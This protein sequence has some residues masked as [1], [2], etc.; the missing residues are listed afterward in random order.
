MVDLG[1]PAG[2]PPSAKSPFLILVDSC[3]QANPRAKR[4]VDPLRMRRRG[5][6]RRR[7]GRL[8]REM[9]REG[10]RERHA[11]H[12]FEP[13][14]GPGTGSEAH[15]VG[16]DAVDVRRQVL[17]RVRMRTRAAVP[18]FDRARLRPP[19]TQRI[20]RRA[21]GADIVGWVNLHVRCRG[22]KHRG[23]SVFAQEAAPHG[24]MLPRFLRG[25]GVAAVQHEKRGTEVIVA[26]ALHAHG[27][28]EKVVLRRGVTRRWHLLRRLLFLLFLLLLLFFLLLLR[29]VFLPLA[30]P[31]GLRL[32]LAQLALVRVLE[33]LEQRED[34]YRVVL[35]ALRDVIVVGVRRGVDRR[36]RRHESKGGDLRMSEPHETPERPDVRAHAAGSRDEQVP[37]AV[38]AQPEK[39]TAQPAARVGMERRQETRAELTGGPHA[40]LQREPAE[41]LGAPEQVLALGSPVTGEE[42]R[43]GDSIGV[44][45]DDQDARRIAGPGARH[46]PKP[47]AHLLSGVIT[48]NSVPRAELFR[49]TRV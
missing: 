21:P 1:D 12:A 30:L 23:A 40:V 19:P 6:L 29:T 5:H 34:A 15:L 31:L 10:R 14:E 2:G 18:V 33:P 47:P 32:H 8:V 17:S 4:S 43:R 45:A 46:P 48:T 26:R 13:G 27:V 36:G 20:A 28:A 39:R 16:D 44:R 22:V 7:R 25:G 35:V 38:A 42:Q 9:M 49:E 11:A 37:V 3:A 24:R 41:S